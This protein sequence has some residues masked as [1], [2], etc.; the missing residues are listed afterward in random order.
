MSELRAE[1]E[2]YV[3]GFADEERDAALAAFLRFRD[4]LTR[5]EV[6]AAD[7]TVYPFHC[8]AIADG[9]RAIEIGAAVSFSLLA[10]LGR[11]EA[12]DIRPA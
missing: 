9:T 12:T 5:G 11:Y 3:R 2:R 1:I 8:I 6:R 10:K 7:G 4:A